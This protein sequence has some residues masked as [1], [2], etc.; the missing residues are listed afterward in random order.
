M[1]SIPLIWLLVERFYANGNLCG[2]FKLNVAYVDLDQD[3]LMLKPMVVM[4]SRGWI[5][6]E[7][8]S[9]M[10]KYEENLYTL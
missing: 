2:Q 7:L 6:L 4:I 10:E 3:Q 9:L 8:M 1:I 5:F